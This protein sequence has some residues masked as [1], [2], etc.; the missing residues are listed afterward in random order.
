M[1]NTSSTIQS[2]IPTLIASPQ[3][4]HGFLRLPKAAQS[5]IVFFVALIGVLVLALLLWGAFVFVRRW[6]RS[7]SDHQAAESGPAN[8]AGDGGNS[9]IVPLAELGIN[10][11]IPREL[12]SPPPS[13]PK[14]R[15]QEELDLLKTF[16]MDTDTEIPSHHHINSPTTKSATE[17][18]PRSPAHDIPVPRS[19][20][21]D[22]ASS[23][24]VSRRRKSSC[25][26]A[27]LSDGDATLHERRGRS[28]RRRTS[29]KSTLSETWLRAVAVFCRSSSRERVE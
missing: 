10:A 7:K 5:A 26:I 27:A 21:Y 12:M 20:Q 15:T 11:P 24:N 1:T 13:H 9:N 23:V 8:L 28:R 16:E 6:R 25:S 3:A 2:S 19:S 18:N 29:E 4:G 17:L 22:G 14:P